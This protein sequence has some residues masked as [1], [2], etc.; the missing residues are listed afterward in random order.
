M[1]ATAARIAEVLAGLRASSARLRTAAGMERGHLP[2]GIAAIDEALGGGLPR[3]RLTELVGPRS[4]GR[5]SI[6][7]GAL[8]AAQQ[9]GELVAVVDVADAFDPRSA[10]AAGVTLA[11]LLW[12]RPRSL[13]AGL[14]AAD[15]VLDAGGFG[16]LVLYLCGAAR[17]R[18]RGDVAWARLA[19]R[20][21]TAR[22]AVLV[23]GEWAQVGSFAA[24][25][26]E[27]R[28]ARV[29]WVGDGAGR[30]L[31][32]SGGQVRVAR[33]KVGLPGDEAPLQL[34]VATAIA[35]GW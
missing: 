13:V 33:S 4:S 23:T 5:M 12:V 17:Q 10:E 22:A 19:Q 9:Q 25:T 16:L 24:A 32:G 27:S 2:L 14:Q 31:E 20:T 1:A 26:L 30:L 6:A 28:R 35:I 29:H 15:R 34:A 3:G 21:E 11:R 18:V 7:L 8:A